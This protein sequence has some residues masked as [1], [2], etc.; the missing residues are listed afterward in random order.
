VSSDAALSFLVVCE[1]A[2]DLETIALLGDRVA[3]AEHAW[4]DGIIASMRAWIGASPRETF[5]AWSLEARPAAV[6]L[7]HDSDGDLD[8]WRSS[9]E[10]ARAEFCSAGNEPSFRVVIGVA[11]PE[12]E[13]WILAGFEPRTIDEV[14]RLERLRAELGFSPC[15][16][17]ELLTSAR[18]TQKR[19]AKRVL[20]HLTG[21]DQDR[22]RRC[23]QEAA[24][25]T[26]RARG[27]AIGLRAF[28]TELQERLGP[29]YVGR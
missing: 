24:L 28:L 13:A 27:E 12:R 8:G 23:L 26:L 22:G 2:A 15:E 11:H 16:R 10:A 5:V 20:A 18:E 1:A 6:L 14:S 25:D 29:C 9:L 17:G 7:V 21:G 4:L 19:D 3:C